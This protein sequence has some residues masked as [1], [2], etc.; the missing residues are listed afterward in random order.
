MLQCKQ[1]L[2]SLSQTDRNLSTVL[3]NIYII[4]VGS[5]N[6]IVILSE[7]PPADIAQYIV[8]KVHN[9]GYQTQKSRTQVVH[10]YLL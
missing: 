2:Y 6:S 1:L 7:L 4:L 9:P 10:A 5:H 8:T 3:Y